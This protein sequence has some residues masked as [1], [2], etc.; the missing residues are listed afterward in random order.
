MPGFETG[1]EGVEEISPLTEIYC[2]TQAK[3]FPW[4]TCVFIVVID[5]PNR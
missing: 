1:E 4:S 2:A 5:F 3:A